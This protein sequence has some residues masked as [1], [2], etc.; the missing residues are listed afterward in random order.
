MMVEPIRSRN[1]ANQPV[2][3]LR[4]LRKITEEGVKFASPVN[5]DRLFLSPERSIEVQ[6]ALG[7]DIIMQFD[8]CTPHP[9]TE[10]QVRKSMELSARWAARCK[11]QHLAWT[12]EAAPPPRR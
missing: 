4:E 8:E 6:H 10:R 5:G 1:P 12:P 3:F 11:T 7:S 2:E 9:A